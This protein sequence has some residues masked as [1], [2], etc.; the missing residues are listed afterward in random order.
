MPNSDILDDFDF[1]ET[2]EWAGNGEVVAKFYSPVQAEIAAA[3]L[4]SE[5]IHCF[6]AN[7]I[8]Q[9]VV[10]HVPGYIRLHTRTADAE[11]ARQLLEEADVEMEHP[12]PRKDSGQS[13]IIFM[14]I[15]IGLVLAGLLAQAL[16]R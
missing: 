11:R 1:H 14:A 8:A 12:L 15:L 16:R 2:P 10:P 6:L 5:G 9:S 4:R 3:R 7:T 13:A